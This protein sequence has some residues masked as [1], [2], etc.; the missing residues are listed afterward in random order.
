MSPVVMSL[1]GDPQ[2]K[3]KVG[4]SIESIMKDTR[5]SSSRERT[6]TDLSPAAER[7]FPSV[8]VTYAEEG[9]LTSS[10]SSL[11]EITP[12]ISGRE[13]FTG[14]CVT[15]PNSAPVSPNNVSPLCRTDLS[16]VTSRL[17]LAPQDVTSGAAQV[18]QFLSHL[19][20][21]KGVFPG[22]VPAGFSGQLG[23]GY[24]PGQA[25]HSRLSSHPYLLPQHHQAAPLSQYAWLLT[26]QARLYGQPISGN[27][28]CILSI[29]VIPGRNS[30]LDIHVS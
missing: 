22:S 3:P 20:H 29:S 1:Q 8:S 17:N 11:N 9:R 15:S 14:S 27:Y 25:I 4:F 24:P 13:A 21:M 19:Y 23:G 6:S 30:H 7:R 28:K 16:P 10:S 26:R 12:T 2:K 18:Q 5:R